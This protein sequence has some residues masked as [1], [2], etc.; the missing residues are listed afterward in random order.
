VADIHKDMKRTHNCGELDE[1]YVGKEVV[2][3]GWVQRRRDHGGVIFIDLRDRHGITQVVF[4]PDRDP[5]THAKA[6][7][8]RNEYVICV[9]GKVE[10]RPDDMINP[11]I[12]TGTIEVF[13]SGLS[14]LNTAKTPPFMVEDRIEVADS[15]G[16]QGLSCAKP[17][18]PRKFLRAPPVATAF[19]A[20]ADDCRF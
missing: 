10:K 19:Q 18:Q 17:C 6:H 7:G 14:I 4:N 8:I 15:R 2:L 11:K 16:C 9:R 20:A 12:A 3:A 5:V 13:A 1:S